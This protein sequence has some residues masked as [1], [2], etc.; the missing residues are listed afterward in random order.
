MKFPYKKLPSGRVRPIIP[1]QVSYKG[2]KSLGYFALVDS[3]ADICIFHTEIADI[4]GIK[5]I[6]SG[7]KSLVGGITQG[8]VQAYYTHPV[9]I[10]VGGWNYDI[11]VAFMPT[12]SKLGY[13]LLGQSGFFSIFSI[14]FDFLKEEIELK[15]YKKK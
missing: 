5:N 10:T 4:I 1:L 7:R 13:G 9:T 14:K 12:L 3:G 6:E 8:E 15:E 2:G 11:E